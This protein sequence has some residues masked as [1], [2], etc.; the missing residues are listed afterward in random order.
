MNTNKPRFL[1]FLKIQNNGFYKLTGIFADS[2][3]GLFYL[4][5]RYSLHKCII[6]FILFISYLIIVFYSFSLLLNIYR[7]LYE[8]LNNRIEY[9]PNLGWKVFLFGI[10]RNAFYTLIFLILPPLFIKVLRAL[11]GLRWLF[12]KFE[13]SENLAYM[14]NAFHIRYLNFYNNRIAFQVDRIFL[15]DCKK[16]AALK[17]A[18]FKRIGLAEDGSPS[19]NIYIFLLIGF[20]FYCLFNFTGNIE[21]FPGGITGIYFTGFISIYVLSHIF[22]IFEYRKKI[23]KRNTIKQHN[24]NK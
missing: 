7:T 3:T 16:Y 23:F 15:R 24:N 14:N 2:K 6:D 21:D 1:E 5:K 20:T 12:T 8:L 17:C 19:K 4:E 22:S 11:L 13:H 9:D 18:Y 10:A